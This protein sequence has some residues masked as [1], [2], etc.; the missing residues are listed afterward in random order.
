MNNTLAP[1]PYSF[2]GEIVEAFGPEVQEKDIA[3][4]LWY[5][6]REDLKKILRLAETNIAAATDEL[7]EARRVAD[8]EFGEGWKVKVLYYRD[9]KNIRPLEKRGLIY[10]DNG[11]LQYWIIPAR[12]HRKEN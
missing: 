1:S 12:R 4:A 5:Y 10:G 6:T 3:A 8:Q 7:L 2:A 9:R 11:I